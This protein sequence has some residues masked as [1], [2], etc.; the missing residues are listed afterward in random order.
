MKI[1]HKED[2]VALRRK[3]YPDIG[4]QLDD[5]WKLFQ[6]VA[7]LNPALAKALSDSPTFQ[8]IQQVKAK[9]PKPPGVA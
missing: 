7:A 9:I 4:D 8:R 2:P 1:S 5:L 6:V 3:N